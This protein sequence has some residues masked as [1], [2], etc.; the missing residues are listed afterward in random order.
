[1]AGRG[2]KHNTIGIY[3]L[4]GGLV[5]LAL[6]LDYLSSLSF[7][8]PLYKELGIAP[9]VT[10]SLA[11][12]KATAG[13]TILASLYTVIPRLSDMYMLLSKAGTALAVS[14][15]FAGLVALHHPLGIGMALCLLLLPLAFGNFCASYQTSN[16]VHTYLRLGII[17]FVL[18]LLDARM[19]LLMPLFIYSGTMVSSLSIKP[20]G[21]LLIGI[22]A[23]SM[24][25]ITHFI[26]V[27]GWSGMLA[28]LEL[29][30]RPLWQ[31]E[32]IGKAEVLRANWDILLLGTLSLC[33]ALSYNVGRS[34]ES[35]RQRRQGG[36][37]VV[38]AVVTA[39]LLLIYPSPMLAVANLLATS[40]L[41]ARALSFLDSKPYNIALGILALVIL[42]ISILI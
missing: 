1:M 20:F 40:L 38:W 17:V 13:I 36:I 37:L 34:T 9:P 26:Y 29:W 18:S 28:L 10:H 8:A 42:S 33:S 23:P 7:F 24:I 12:T 41:S 32:F 4:G 39:V 3:V 31:I 25:L 2:L 19:L 27:L 14:L 21:A 5:L 22:L 16:E 6:G 30:L 11:H 35:I 15:C